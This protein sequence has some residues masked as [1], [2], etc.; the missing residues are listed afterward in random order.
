M[1]IFFLFAGLVLFA[2][3]ALAQQKQF[4]PKIQFDYELRL[5]VDFQQREA[6][7]KKNGEEP[8]VYEK[9][10]GFISGSIYAADITDIVE[11]SGTKYQINS[12]GIL[13]SVLNLALQSQKL[14]RQSYGDVTKDGLS[15]LSY[16]EKRGNTERL[17]AKL[18]SKANKV[19]FIKDKTETG[20]APIAGNLLD[21]LNVMY[22]FV[23][24]KA[25]PVKATYNVTDS[26]SLKQYTLNKG[27]LW[28]FPFNGVKVKAY[29]YFKST[30]KDDS[31]TLEIWLTEKDN[32]PLR[33]VVGLGERYGATIQADLKAIP[34]I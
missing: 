1:K 9:A 32:I 13:T 21:L 6:F 33:M 12:T 16:I 23:G 31:A 15:T 29:R 30:T 18:D 2:T 8:A 19:I 27:E 20:S 10:M 22:T 34:S 26:K 28:D 5:K 11:M 25:P 7:L 4:P 3:G 14:L 17:Q 24:R